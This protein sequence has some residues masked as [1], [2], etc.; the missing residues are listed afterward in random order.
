MLCLCLHCYAHLQSS[1]CHRGAP[2]AHQCHCQQGIFSGSAAGRGE[3]VISARQVLIDSPDLALKPLMPVTLKSIIQVPDMFAFARLTPP[4]LRLVQCSEAL[5]ATCAAPATQACASHPTS[6]RVP[7]DGPTSFALGPRRAHRD[8]FPVTSRQ[9][10]PMFGSSWVAHSMVCE[11]VLCLLRRPVSERPPGT[12][13][14][15]CCLPVC[16]TQLEAKMLVRVQSPASPPLQC[17]CR[18][19]S[20]DCR[21]DGRTC[22]ADAQRSSHASLE[23]L[24]RFKLSSGGDFLPITSGLRHVST[25]H[26][27]FQTYLPLP[28]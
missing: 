18:L 9:A 21:G 23:A 5:R 8:P 26:T 15:V 14:P 10:E 28:G 7:F 11:G 20:L 13:H 16:R 17:D 12:N 1:D 22:R 27:S 2:V 6:T 24:P 19:D 4:S 25:Q 3:P